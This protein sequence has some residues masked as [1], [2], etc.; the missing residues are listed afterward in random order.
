MIY[1]KYSHKE[2]SKQFLTILLVL[3]MLITAYG[4]AVR[5]F[6]GIAK[7]GGTPSWTDISVG[8][9]LVSFTVLFIIADVFNRTSWAKI[10]VPAGRSTLTT[11][12][13][14]YFY[15]AIMSLI[16]LY[17]PQFLRGGVFG[18]IKSLL[19]S[20]LII[21]ITTLFEKAHLKLRI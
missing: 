13:I 15:Y 5:P 14:P 2:S 6:G 7:L 9:G 8:V 17:L 21:W 19:F 1:L 3:A 16:A 12:L 10:F 18:I 20:F 4:F 11:Y